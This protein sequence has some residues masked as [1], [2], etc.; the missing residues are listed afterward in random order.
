MEVEL[1]E[2]YAAFDQAFVKLYPTFVDEFNELLIPEARIVLKK[3]ES[4]NTQLRIFALI[5]LGIDQPAQ[6]AHFL[7]YSPTT[8]YNYRSQAKAAALCDKEDFE[9][10]VKRIAGRG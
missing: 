9:E 1:K 8:V 7:R 3:G 2:F 5:R 4:L 10:S 6:I